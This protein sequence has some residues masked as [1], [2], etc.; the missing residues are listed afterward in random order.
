[1]EMLFVSELNP[2]SYQLFYRPL[3]QLV[4]LP[5][6]LLVLSSLDVLMHCHVTA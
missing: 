5:T 3:I 1:M 6:P 2:T 4:P